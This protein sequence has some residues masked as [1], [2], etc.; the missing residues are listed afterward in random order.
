MQGR[1][2]IPRKRRDTVSEGLAYFLG[3]LIPSPY[4]ANP[5]METGSLPA[6]GISPTR[7]LMTAASEGG[8]VLKVAR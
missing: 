4:T 3:T 2:Q 1:N 5:G 8:A 7:A 6:M